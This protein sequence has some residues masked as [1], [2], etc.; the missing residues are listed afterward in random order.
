M[1]R[2][3]FTLFEIIVAIAIV[4]MLMGTMAETLKTAFQHKASA[5][6]AI[7]NVRDIQTVG[8]IFVQE[9]ACAVPPNP[10]SGAANSLTINATTAPSN[11]TYSGGINNM[12]DNGTGTGGLYLFGPFLGD[13]ISLSFFTTGS[14][15]K[16]DVQAGVRYIEFRLSQQSNGDLALVRC[17][18]TNL[19]AD[20]PAIVLPEEV[21]VTGV[22][23][24]QFQYFNSIGWLDAWDSTGVDNNNTLPIAVKM[25]LTLAPLRDGAP[26]RVITRV[27]TVWC[28]QK[29]IN[30]YNV[31]AQ[32]ASTQTGITTP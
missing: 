2:R 32:A 3:G 23:A 7:A 31:A 11:G 6:Y 27:A 26:D 24:V 30:D 17:V 20:I 8:D 28:A 15:P 12:N 14:E 25:I 1:S 29:T 22:K 13:S 19:L 4:V 16:A 21:L 5:E 18:D 10:L 9:L